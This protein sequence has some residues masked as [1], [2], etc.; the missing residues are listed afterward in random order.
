MQ[1]IEDE[2]TLF[3][4]WCIIWKAVRACPDPS[5]LVALAGR[6]RGVEPLAV[7]LAAWKRGSR[8]LRWSR[9]SNRSS[10]R[11]RQR[12]PF[13]LSQPNFEITP[14]SAVEA[15]EPV[16]SIDDFELSFRKNSRLSRKSR[17]VER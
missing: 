2:H 11:S 5:A 14:P 9:Q 1:L 8:F 16:P 4:T 3:S 17:V 15:P 12:K 7:P 6:L 13:P 10:K